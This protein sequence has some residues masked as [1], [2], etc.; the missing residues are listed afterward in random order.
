MSSSHSTVTHVLAS[1]SHPPKLP[2]RTMR[3]VVVSEK[4][5]LRHHPLLSK[6]LGGSPCGLSYLLIDFLPVMPCQH[7]RSSSRKLHLTPLLENFARKPNVFSI[8]H[9][10]SAFRSLWSQD[11]TSMGG[12]GRGTSQPLASHFGKREWAPRQRHSSY[13][14]PANLV[15]SSVPRCSPTAPSRC[16]RQT[17]WRRRRASGCCRGSRAGCRCR[18]SRGSCCA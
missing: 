6:K 17:L 5:T 10:L 14:Q 11:F 12:G 13:R 16:S 2:L 18:R 15:T 9:G 4:T 7:P 1:Q 3:G 8:L